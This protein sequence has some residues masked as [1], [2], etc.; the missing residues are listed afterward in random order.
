MSV[1]L[2]YTRTVPNYKFLRF[3]LFH[4]NLLLSDH[5][6]GSRN[7]DY[8]VIKHF[9]VSLFYTRTRKQFFTIY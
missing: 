6:I 5:V 7:R 9:Y 1:C 4:L 2:I 3:I 8:S